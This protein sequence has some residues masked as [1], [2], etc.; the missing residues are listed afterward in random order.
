MLLILYLIMTN[1]IVFDYKRFAVHDGPGIRQTVFLK[2]CPL[3]CWWC[4]NPESQQKQP[5]TLHYEQSLVSHTHDSTRTTGHKQTVA[6]VMAQIDKDHLFY[7]ESAGGIS[8]S[9]GEPLMQP[10]FLLDL[11]QASKQRYY[12]TVVDTSGFAAWRHFQAILPYTDLFLYD[13]KLIDEATHRQYTGQS[14][15]PVLYNLRQLLA[16]SHQVVIRVPLI[17][18]ITTTK[19]NLQAMRRF[20]LSLNAPLVLQL[21]PYHR[22]A[23]QKYERLGMPWRMHEAPD[24]PKD[25]AWHYARY[26]LHPQWQ[27]QVGSE[28]A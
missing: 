3:H 2:G 14:N 1:G 27:V 11:L 25:E 9:G 15:R 12:H 8:F 13:L 24:M 19:A 7:E 28:M 21:L 16:H 4:H 26:L 22:I 23:R 6:E 20:L 17:P 18:Q 10:Q 5:Q